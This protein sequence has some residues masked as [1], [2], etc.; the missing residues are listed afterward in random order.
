V[1]GLTLAGAALALA[2]LEIYTLRHFGRVMPAHLGANAEALQTS[3][4][5]ERG[6]LITTWFRPPAWT[7]S[8]P[9]H[10]ETIWIAAPLILLAF[11]P[12][13]EDVL[14]AGR[15]FLWI[16]AGLTI[17][18]VLLTAPNDGGGQWAPR[19]LLFAFV[20]LVILAADVVTLLPQRTPT[21]AALGLVLL[22]CLWIDRSGYR[23]LRSTKNS[24]GRIVDFIDQQVAPGG[25]IVTDLWWLDQVGAA[26][27][28]ARRIVYVPDEANGHAAMERLSRAVVPIVVVL[29]SES[30]STS[31]NPWRED[32]CYVEIKRE[33]LDVRRLVAVTLH[34]RCGA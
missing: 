21:M 34:H 3:W 9:L 1:F 27:A 6:H 12:I 29:R 10:P 5:A 30:E 17:I 8:R 18:L 25:F 4:L 14:P 26:A 19:Y 7:W 23:E 33:T 32:T 22:A 28:T 13:R 16:A 31:M 20:P 15:R 24:Y 2:P 11:V